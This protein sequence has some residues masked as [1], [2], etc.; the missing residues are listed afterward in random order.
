MIPNGM[1][2]LVY[3]GEKSKS[4]VLSEGV[5]L[6]VRECSS[7]V[8]QVLRA[9]PENPPVIFA[10]EPVWAIGAQG[11][12]SANHVLTVLQSLKDLVKTFGGKTEVRIL[13]GGSAKPGYGLY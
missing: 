2:P 9:V 12:P 13:Y 4:S 5:G 7:Q 1:I 8:T 6:A 3:I 11:P 10:Y